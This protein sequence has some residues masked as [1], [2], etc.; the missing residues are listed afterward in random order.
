MVADAVWQSRTTSEARSASAPDGAAEARL[1]REATPLT[2]PEALSAYRF[3]HHFLEFYGCMAS[4]I[5]RCDVETDGVV[6]RIE[7]GFATSIR[8]S[9]FSKMGSL[10]TSN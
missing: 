1:V 2:C 10:C 4:V 8:R 6:W 7:L 9:I 5:L 3:G